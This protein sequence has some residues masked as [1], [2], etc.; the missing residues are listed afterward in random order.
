MRAPSASP[1]RCWMK[2]MMSPSTFDWS[3][4]ISAPSSP[5]RRR[6]LSSICWRVTGPYISGCRRPSVFRLGPLISSIRIFS[7][8][9]LLIRQAR[10][11]PHLIIE[12]AVIHA[13]LLL[14]RD[15]GVYLG[16]AGAGVTQQLLHDP[17]LGAAVQQVGGERVAQQVREDA[18]VQ[19]GHEGVLAHD[20][21]HGASG[22]A[23]A[24]P[25]HEQRRLTRAG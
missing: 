1:A 9:G 18:L 4:S 8:L 24:V 19:A 22:E 15:V 10:L 20:I 2:P 5:A 16:G 17:Q 25:V 12:R 6:T 14:L 21:L 11:Q 7:L 23:L 3:D 13:P